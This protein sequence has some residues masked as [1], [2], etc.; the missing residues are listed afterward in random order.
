MFSFGLYNIVVELVPL[1]SV[2][3]YYGITLILK[4]I[5]LLGFFVRLILKLGFF[6][7]FKHVS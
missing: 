3:I 1:I 7:F 2:K 5:S 4:L 6:H